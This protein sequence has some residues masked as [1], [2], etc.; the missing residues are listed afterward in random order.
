[1][2]RSP[3]S[4]IA[5]LA[6]VAA[7]L[8]LVAGPARAE[9][10][11]YRVPASATSD[12]PGGVCTLGAA[13]VQGTPVAAF[14][15]Y[16]G[17]QTIQA[18]VGTSPHETYVIPV[19]G[20]RQGP[21]R[22]LWLMSY[23]AVVW[24]FSLAPVNR[25]EAVILS[26]YYDQAAMNL[27]AHIPVRFSSY[28]NPGACG[29]LGYAYKGGRELEAAVE[30]LS[31]ATGL[32]V[33]SFSGSYAVP[34]VQF[35]AVLSPLAAVPEV[36]AGPLRSAVSVLPDALPAR[37]A[38]LAQLIEQGKLR[39]ATQTDVDR[40]NAAAT[41]RL[42]T[43]R[44]APFTSSYLSASRSYVILAPIQIPRGMYG[45]HSATFIVPAG[46]PSPRDPGSH[47]TYFRLA[48]GTCSGSSPDC[49]R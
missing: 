14:G 12:D 31:A 43:G 6:L 5:G 41:A 15:V 20:P 35:G 7:V 42:A 10:R 13:R 37:E 11:V 22:V 27:P 25:I 23:E 3:F 8:A 2:I 17:R 29:R 49:T 1:M 4:N 48:D 28:Q 34:G 44:L 21:P 33:E 30:R 18:V 46:V 16:E 40:W 24:D 26:G 19:T 38:G 32:S 36:R 45:A 39:H 47:N 9:P